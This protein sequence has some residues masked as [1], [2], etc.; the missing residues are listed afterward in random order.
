M[1]SSLLI[2]RIL[3]VFDVTVLIAVFNF[4]VI[5]SDRQRLTFDP[6]TRFSIS[7]QP[8]NIATVYVSAKIIF[9]QKTFDELVFLKHIVRRLISGRWWNETCNVVNPIGRLGSSKFIRPYGC[10]PIWAL[11]SPRQFIVLPTFD[12]KN[13]GC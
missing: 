1:V 7:R 2:T 3:V 12:R 6:T 10:S 9:E 11:Y 13:T 5:G 8:K 4:S